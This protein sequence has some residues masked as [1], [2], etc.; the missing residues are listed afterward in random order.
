LLSCLCDLDEN[1]VVNLEETQQLEDFARFGCD[2]IDASNLDDKIH[3]QLS[4]C[5]EITNSPCGTFET[6]LLLLRR[7]LLHIALSALENDFSLRLGCCSLA[8]G[9][10]LMNEIL[11][12]EDI[13]FVRATIR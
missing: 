5:V 12:R 7:V 10:D 6:G 9:E 1:A 3:L 2:L 13:I 11:D 8:T 4:R